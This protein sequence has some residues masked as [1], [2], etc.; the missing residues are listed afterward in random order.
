MTLNFTGGKTDE[1]HIFDGEQYMMAP[2]ISHSP[3]LLNRRQA[4]EYCGISPSTFDK[5][6][7]L[8]SWEVCYARHR[9]EGSIN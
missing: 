5:N 8:W 2:A 6:S 9:T 7:N 4:A 3:R 1:E